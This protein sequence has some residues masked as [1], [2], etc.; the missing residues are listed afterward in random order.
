MTTTAVSI[1][2]WRRSDPRHAP[3]LWLKMGLVPGSDWPL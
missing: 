1:S 3:S 2:G